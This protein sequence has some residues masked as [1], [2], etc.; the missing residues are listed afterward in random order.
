MPLI[1]PLAACPNKVH[2]NPSIDMDTSKVLSFHV[3]L[4]R[5][6]TTSNISSQKSCSNRLHLPSIGK[7]DEIHLRK[8]KRQLC[9]ISN[10]RSNYSPTILTDN[11]LLT[12]RSTRIDL[13]T[14]NN[15]DPPEAPPSTPMYDHRQTDVP[16][17]NNSIGLPSIGSTDADYVPY[18]LPALHRTKARTRIDVNRSTRFTVDMRS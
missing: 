3:Y 4:S 16:L 8:N 9:R 14:S 2:V 17:V 11:W 18:R 5:Y 13:S 15:D 12:G 6:A 10:Q 7:H 1:E